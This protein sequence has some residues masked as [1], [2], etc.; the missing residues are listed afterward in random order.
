[1]ANVGRLSNA[2]EMFA[3]EFDDN[4][5]TSFS[6]SNTSTVFSNEFD[7]NT[8]TTLSGDQRMSNTSGGGSYC[9]RFY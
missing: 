4:T 6:I 2:G 8:S 7:E 3:F 1:M 9:F 5:N